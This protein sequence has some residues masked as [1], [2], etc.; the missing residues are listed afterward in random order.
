VRTNALPECSDPQRDSRR[1]NRRDT[2][3]PRPPFRWVEFLGIGGVL[4]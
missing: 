2:P 4:R 3:P 1:R